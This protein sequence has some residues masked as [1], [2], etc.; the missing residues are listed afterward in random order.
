MK[1]PDDK[2]DPAKKDDKKTPPAG[3][4]GI[5]SGGSSSDTKSKTDDKPKTPDPNDKKR[6]LVTKPA[7]NG[8]KPTVP[9]SPSVSPPLK[10]P[11]YFFTY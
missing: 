6:V 3:G 11:E 2:A 10:E 1:K 9:A 5:S 8:S 4:S 7:P